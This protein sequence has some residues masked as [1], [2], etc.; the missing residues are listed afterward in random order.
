M[1]GE[2]VDPVVFP[3]EVP[4]RILV[5]AASDGT[6]SPDTALAALDGGLALSSP[7]IRG[8][9]VSRVVVILS[10]TLWRPERIRAFSARARALAVSGVQFIVLGPSGGGYYAQ[11]TETG[12]DPIILNVLGGVIPIPPHMRDRT[13]P[14]FDSSPQ[15]YRNWA[16]EHPEATSFARQDARPLTP[17]EVHAHPGNSPR[18]DPMIVIPRTM[19]EN[20]GRGLPGSGPGWVRDQIVEYTLSSLEARG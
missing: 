1:F 4:Q 11:V 7:T 2:G 8:V 17:M 15:T 13:H 19:L 9:T 14:Q 6:E 3:G 20:H 16:A 5:R 18:L 10:D 12:V